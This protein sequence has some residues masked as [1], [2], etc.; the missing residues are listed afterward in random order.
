MENIDMLPFIP[1]KNPNFTLEADNSLHD[2]F[3]RVQAKFTTEEAR[4]WQAID[5]Q[6]DNASLEAR[7]PGAL[8]CIQRFHAQGW[9]E[10]VEP[11]FPQ[12]RRAVL[13]IEPHMDDAAFS[14]GGLMW[15]RRM[16]CHFTVLS[17]VGIS[18]YTAGLGFTPPQLNGKDEVTAL[19]KAESALMARCIG[20]RHETLSMTDAPLRYPN[21]LH[22]DTWPPDWFTLHAQAISALISHRASQN[23]F[24]QLEGL[25][26]AALD[27]FSFAELWLPLGLGGHSDHELTRDVWLQVFQRKHLQCTVYFYN[28][29]PY[30]NRAATHQ[31]QILAA[32]NQQH[33]KT[34]S[35]T[36]AI[37]EAMEGKRRLSAIYRTQFQPEEIWPQITQAATDRTSALPRFQETLHQLIRLPTPLDC[38]QLYSRKHI[39]ERLGNQLERWIPPRRTTKRIRLF[40]S[41]PFGHWADDIK[42][43]MQAFPEA[44]L[45]IQLVPDASTEAQDYQH[46][47]AQLIPC[48]SKLR[49]ALSLL[50][51]LLSPWRGPVLLIGSEQVSRIIQSDL[52]GR[53]LQHA[54]FFAAATASDFVTALLDQPPRSSTGQAAAI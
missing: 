7:H 27:R 33:G 1:L 49:F 12:T 23:E 25:I 47:R 15:S 8:A 43:I 52:T 31:T 35:D 16:N 40:V 50:S 41:M 34:I 32:L 36:Y 4:V 17:M 38:S 14:V 53:I 9:C 3:S 29:V 51:A 21:A 11:H 26:E 6:T 46:P 10:C 39:V 5:G 30:V 42:Q 28:D 18:N 44:R 37:D 22:H 54:H 20:G 24:T 48:Y 13:V 45:E 19:R 2:F